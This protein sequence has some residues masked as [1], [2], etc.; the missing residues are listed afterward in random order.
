MR[1]AGFEQQQ[2]PIVMDFA[3]E[4]HHIVRKRKTCDICDAY[5]TPCDE[6]VHTAYAAMQLEEIEDELRALE[7]AKARGEPA[8]VGVSIDEVFSPDHLAKITQEI[9]RDNWEMPLGKLL[10]ETLDFISSGYIYYYERHWE[11]TP[12]QKRRKRVM[13]V[14]CSVCSA[15]MPDDDDLDYEQALKHDTYCVVAQARILVLRLL[16]HAVRAHMD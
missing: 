4:L 10:A 2:E 8:A 16:A 14:H 5:E 9:E 6:V 12:G 11:R 1:E 3:R 15:H 7:E 13:Y